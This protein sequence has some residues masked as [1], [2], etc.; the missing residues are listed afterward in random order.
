[1]LNR[2]MVAT[3][4]VRKIQEPSPNAKDLI[5]SGKISYVISTSKG[6]ANPVAH[7]S[8]RL[9]RMAVERGVTCLTSLDTAKA[10]AV[11]LAMGKTMT[12]IELTCI[13]DL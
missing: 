12:D 13:N 2:H 7:P 1:M 6:G 4:S 8:V 11:V 10:L 3:N 5:E 9:R